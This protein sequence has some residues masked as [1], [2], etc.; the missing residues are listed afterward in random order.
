MTLIIINC[1]I[2]SDT[3]SSAIERF[4]TT[5]AL[6]RIHPGYVWMSSLI[7]RHVMQLYVAAA[8]LL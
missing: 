3:L 8:Q 7:S 1:S 4:P 6:R 2:I 5:K